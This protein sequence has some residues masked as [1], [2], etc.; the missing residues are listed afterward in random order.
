MDNAEK[1]ATQDTQ[2]KGEQHKNT[3][4]YMLDTTVRKQTQIT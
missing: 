2:D 3:K 4:Q 1:L